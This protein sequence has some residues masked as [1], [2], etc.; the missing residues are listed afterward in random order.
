[1]TI[2]PTRGASEVP[3]AAWTGRAVAARTVRVAL[4]V[5]PFLFGWL[6][7]R[8]AQQ[9]FWTTTDELFNFLVWIAQA[10]IVAIVAT[11]VGTMVANRFAPL[12]TLLNMTLVF[13]DQA[14]SRFGIALRSG[15][16]R[17]LRRSDLVLSDDAQVAAEQ[18]IA[19]VTRLGKHERLTRGHSERVRAYAELI[20]EEMGLDQKDLNRLRWGVLLHDIGKLAV[21]AS[22]LASPDRPTEAEWKALKLHPAAGEK[23]LRPLAGWLGEWC[24]ASSQHH[25]RWDGNGYPA[26]LSGTQISLA[27]RIT[28]VADAYDVITSNRSYKGSLSS[29]SGRAELVKCAGSQFDP[30]VVRAFLR[31]GLHEPRRN[32]GIMSWVLEL[33]GL[34]RAA[35]SVASTPSAVASAVAVSVAATAGSV[36]D[37]IPETLPFADDSPPVV[38]ADSQLTKELPPPSTVVFT[39]PTTSG[40]AAVVTTTTPTGPTP[41]T[42][43]QAPMTTTSSAAS[44][45][46]TTTAAAATTT[47]SAAATTTTSSAAATTTTSTTTTKVPTSGLTAVDDYVTVEGASNVHIDVLA[48]DVAGAAPIERVEIISPPSNADWFVEHNGHYD[49]K[50]LW[51][52][53]GEDRYVYE[54]CDTD[55]LCDQ[56]VVFLTITP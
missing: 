23:I 49:Y 42:S 7:V 12:P 1:M 19:L 27:G 5:G 20:G 47:T 44:A 3:G 54:I 43:S 38:V 31:I 35:T 34:A 48:N 22:I 21:P 36:A 10:V 46:T 11:R 14:P 18:A 30:V 50:P 37:A 56:A 25:E 2:G 9:W 45:T 51:G 53:V 13:P 4:F 39:V 52:F 17:K 24:L 32:M 33:P 8:V 40:V 16:V 29:Q 26:G 28:A 55:G 6:A 15:S 41:T